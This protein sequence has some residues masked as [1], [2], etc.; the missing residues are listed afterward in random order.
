VA[1]AVVGQARRA[2]QLDLVDAVVAAHQR[3]HEALLA[4]HGTDLT[5]RSADAEQRGDVLAGL[6][7]RR[8]DL[9]H[10][11]AGRRRARPGATASASSTLAA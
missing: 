3:Q 2:C 6:L 1:S 11:F 7:R 9:A 8:V 5:V 4:H 10:R